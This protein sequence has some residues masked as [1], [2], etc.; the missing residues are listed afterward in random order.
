MSL[1][2]DNPVTAATLVEWYNQVAQ[3]AKLKASE[4][5]LRQ[6][7]FKHFFKEPKEGANTHIMDDGYQLKADRV[8]NRKVD[9]PLYKSMM[10]EFVAQ[11]INPH[12]LVRYKPE[13]NT[14]AYR[15]L[16]LEQQK[17]FDQCLIVTD[18]SP[19]LKIAAPSKK[20]K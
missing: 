5:L 19:S 12:A 2:P 1:I 9:E 6:K 15:E 4:M 7:I 17:F 13:L 18:G 20:G 3:M 10:E 8:I 11:G 16:T 14:T